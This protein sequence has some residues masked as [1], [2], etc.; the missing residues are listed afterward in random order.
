MKGTTQFK[1]P[2]DCSERERQEFARLVREG[3]NGS[4]EGL[5][6]RIDRAR[7][8]AF[9]Y[10]NDDSLAAIAGLKAPGEEYRRDVF[11]RAAVTVSPAAYEVELGWVYVVP[12]RRGKSIAEGLCRQLLG[13]L[14]DIGVFATTRPNNAPMTRVLLALGFEQVGRPYPRRHEDLV[15]FL[16][17][18]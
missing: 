14:P 6:D 16:R 11:E 8:L 13:S 15:V 7:L 4:D 10:A 12:P 9:Y 5:P 1:E 3:F 17:S 18:S 2:A